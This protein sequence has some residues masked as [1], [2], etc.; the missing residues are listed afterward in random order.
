MENKIQLWEFAYFDRQKVEDYLSSIEDGLAVERREISHGTGAELSGKL[1]APGIAEVGGVVGRKGVELQELK[2]ATDASLFGRLRT[3]LSEQGLVR[4]FNT[5]DQ[6]TW[7]LIKTGEILELT[8][9]VEVSAMESLFELSKA[10]LPYVTPQTHDEKTRNMTRL[11]D[12]ISTRE[13]FNVKVML[14]EGNWKFLATL[15]KEKTRVTRQ[16]LSSSYSV[17]CRVQRKMGPDERFLLFSFVPGLT[18]PDDQVEQLIEELSSRGL[19]QL[20]GRKIS[21]EDFVTAP[22]AMIVTPVAVFR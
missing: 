1:G 18:L 20:L 15:S 4:S 14:G 8:G 7:D 6:E 2:K 16:E 12:L 10:I 11:V 13:G 22:P 17:L 19:E 21:F 3:R 5:L 9:S